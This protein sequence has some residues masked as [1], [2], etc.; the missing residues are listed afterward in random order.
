M[1]QHHTTSL[2]PEL[3]REALRLLT[4][5]RAADRTAAAQLLA[6]GWDADEAERQASIAPAD[7]PD[8][9]DELEE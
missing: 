6:H 7:Q 3:V 5:G 8:G 2:P 4:T 1:T 9:Y